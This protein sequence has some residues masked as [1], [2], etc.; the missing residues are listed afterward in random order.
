MSRYWRNMNLR[1]YFV[2][3]NSRSCASSGLKRLELP[4]GGTSSHR[5]DSG[6]FNDSS[7][8]DSARFGSG[9]PAVQRQSSQMN[10]TT[11]VT[12]S[13]PSECYTLS[14]DEL[15]YLSTSVTNN[16]VEPSTAKQR[17]ADALSQLSGTSHS[18]SAADWSGEK[19]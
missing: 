12:Q 9:T 8:Y 16:S 6:R 7:I 11:S 2:C 4:V 13:S 15:R 3:Q 5:S 18:A 19:I 14:A 10:L 17:T 1:F